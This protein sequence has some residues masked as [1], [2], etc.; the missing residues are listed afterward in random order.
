LRVKSPQ[1]LFAYADRCILAPAPKGHPM[2][3]DQVR[4][5]EAMR[6]VYYT[7]A[8]MT[9]VVLAAFLYLFN[10]TS[11]FKLAVPI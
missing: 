2:P 1:R 7:L 4:E 8:A 3:V 5:A 6:Y 10:F 11:F 9:A